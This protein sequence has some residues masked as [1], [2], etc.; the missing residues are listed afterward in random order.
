MAVT[1]TVPL[2][3]PPLL[4]SLFNPFL[5]LQKVP[6]WIIAVDAQM[7]LNALLLDVMEW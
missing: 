3:P 1:A 4:D 5:L 6:L 7:A 2:P